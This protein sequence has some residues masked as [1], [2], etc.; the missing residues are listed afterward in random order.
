L[1]SLKFEFIG[2]RRKERWLK[3]DGS[4]KNDSRELTE[5]V[6]F[7]TRTILDDD[8]ALVKRESSSEESKFVR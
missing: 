7:E 6:E 2:D 1:G 5:L 8:E 3:F 4:L